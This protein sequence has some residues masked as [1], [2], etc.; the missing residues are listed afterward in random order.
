MNAPRAVH[1]A[2]EELGRRLR[3]LRVGAELTG[4][5]LAA[6]LGWP[7]SKISKLE[8]G[9]QA[10]TS[11]DITAWCAACSREDA[12]DALLVLR[13]EMDSRYSEWRRQLGRGVHLRQRP[14][15][16]LDHDT[17]VWR[18]LET[19]VV[20]GLLQTPE[21][22]AA[23]FREAV[24]LR[25]IPDTAEE[26]VALRM[27]R[28]HVLYE[29]GKRFHFLLW[30]PVLHTG[31]ATASVMVDQL[32]R[33]INLLHLPS[34]RIGIIPQNT[35]LPLTP[36]HGFWLRDDQ[37]VLVETFDAELRLALPDEL[38]LYRRIFDLLAPVARYDADARRLIERGINAW[39]TQH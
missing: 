5:T 9:Q 1:E 4:K 18:I 13:Q 21:Y 6:A 19:C 39:Q 31:A 29:P 34:A 35:R 20:P 10:A 23:T 8:L 24:L 7:H 36:S 3:E 17:R 2:R 28:Q 25:G 11:A 37:L 32:Q 38:A 16:D 26:A 30:E 15:I 22:A 33:L 14:L 27:Q 12:I